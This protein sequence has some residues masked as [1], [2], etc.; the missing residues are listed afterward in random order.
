M[1]KSI[2]LIFTTISLIIGFYTLIDIS[3]LFSMC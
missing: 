1:K 3:A 2:A